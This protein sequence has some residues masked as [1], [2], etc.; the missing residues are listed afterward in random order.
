MQCARSIKEDFIARIGQGGI[1]ISREFGN[2]RPLGQCAQ[3]VLIAA[4]Q[5]RVGH[6]GEFVVHLNSAL[7]HDGLDRTDE[8]LIGAHA[9]GDAVE[10]DADSLDFHGWLLC[11][12][13]LDLIALT[14]SI[15]FCD[16]RYSRVKNAME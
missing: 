9:S 4:C 14:W 1:D 10:D 11:S 8:M 7:I 6:D 16:A 5:D 12:S 15:I 3:L 13:C 2:A